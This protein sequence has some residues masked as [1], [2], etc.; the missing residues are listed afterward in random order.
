MVD[1]ILEVREVSKNFTLKRANIFE[2]RQT[3]QAVKNVSLS[4]S[5]GKGLVSLASLA[6]E[7]QRLPE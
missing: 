3:L 1:A 5:L 7:N 6:A 4:S 2:P